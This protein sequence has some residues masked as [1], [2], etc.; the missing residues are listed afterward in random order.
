MEAVLYVLAETIRCLG[1]IVQPFMPESS[2]KILDQVAVPANERA[3]EFLAAAHALKS[4]TPLP[5]PQGVFPRIVDEEKDKA[6][7]G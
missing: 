6:A 4:G 3:F 7:A 5:I 1:I 2:G